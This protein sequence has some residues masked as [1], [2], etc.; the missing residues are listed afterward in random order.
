MSRRRGGVRD[1]LRQKNSASF[2]FFAGII[3]VILLAV[4]AFV[5]INAGTAPDKKSAPPT[6]DADVV[7]PV[8]EDAPMPVAAPY[9][10]G[11]YTYLQGPKSWKKRLEWSGAWGR[12]YKDGGNFGAFGCGLCCLANV[13]STQSSFWC[14]P[15]EMYNFAKKNTSYVGGGAIAWEYMKEV[16]D[17]L[18]FESALFRRPKKYAEF[19]K[20]MSDAKCAI[21]LVSSADSDCY[22]K[23][24]SGH[25]VTIFSYDEKTDRIFLA[26]S[27]D[28]E[29]NRQWVDLKKIYKSLKKAS[30]WQ[31]LKVGSYDVKKD[32]W[33]HEG[34]GG[35]WI[36]PDYIQKK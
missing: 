24:T 35:R 30:D 4:A 17:R 21:V 32:S 25:Y 33:M 14:T 9:E 2:F 27:G 16:L 8:G 5:H 3:C 13:Y 18:G 7:K 34:F 22:W 20:Q 6:E 12:A 26:D 1:F 11:I 19:K 29:H 15:A 36:A 31:Y 23:N 28:P 10:E